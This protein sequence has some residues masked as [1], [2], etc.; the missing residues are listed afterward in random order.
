MIQRVKL[1]YFHNFPYFKYFK[2][3]NLHISFFPLLSSF[4]RMHIFFCIRLFFHFFGKFV[5]LIPLFRWNNYLLFR[6]YVTIFLKHSDFLI[7]FEFWICL[8]IYYGFRVVMRYSKLSGDRVLVGNLIIPY[9]ISKYYQILI[10]SLF[11]LFT[12]FILFK[13]YIR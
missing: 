11:L 8:E 10:L 4:L 9:L 5:T 7:L 2:Y 3:K 1:T 13:Y 12:F 6:N